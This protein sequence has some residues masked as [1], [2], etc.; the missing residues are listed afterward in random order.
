METHLRDSKISN[1][2]KNKDHYDDLY[3]HVSIESIVAKVRNA[4]SFLDKAIKTD[5]SWHGLYQGDFRHQ[6]KGKN[7]LELGCGDGL[8][9]L[10]M[11]KLGGQVT[12]IDISEQ[13]KVIVDK[14]NKECSLPVKAITGEFT[15]ESFE[16]NSFDIVVGKAFLHHLTHEQEELYLEKV[17]K[18]LK[19]TGEARFLEPAMNSRMIDT[20]RWLT[21]VPG[22]PS[23]LN[24]K[25]FAEW[26]ENDPHLV[27]DN[28]TDHFATVGHIFFDV[29]ETVMIGSLERFCRLIP[30]GKF[31]TA[32][33]QWAHRVEPHLPRW[34]R[35]AAARSQLIIY[36]IP[37]KND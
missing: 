10:I 34:F 17:A 9:A 15:N 7:I 16:E 3:S 8:N 19:P 20:L 4:E 25:A 24:R 6:L 33:R 32:Y 36:R 26:K 31:N 5:T 13:S 12:A 14:V 27:R 35:S 37:K 2:D 21:P 23:K 11:A 29:V 18:L 28:S 1:V 30:T 22:R